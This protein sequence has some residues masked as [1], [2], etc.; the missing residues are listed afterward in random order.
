MRITNIS[1][2][3]GSQVTPI[4]ADMSNEKGPNLVIVD[5]FNRAKTLAED[6]SFFSSKNIYVFSHEDNFIKYVAKSREIMHE[7]I[8]ILKAIRNG[9]DCIVISP[10]LSAMKKVISRKNFDIGQIELKV[11]DRIDIDELKLELIKLGYERCDYVEAKGQFSIRGGI[12]DI[13]TIDSETP[14]RIELFD[15]EIDTIRTFEI[16]TQR[17]ISNISRI[18]VNVSNNF[19]IRDEDF[20]SARESL[21]EEYTFH[22]N[23]LKIKS[24]TDDIIEKL[25]KRRDELCEHLD[26]KTNLEVLD[27]YLHYFPDAS[28]Y[29]WNYIEPGCVFVENPQ[30]V[31]EIVKNEESTSAIDFQALL[32][33]GYVIPADWKMNIDKS[34]LYDIYKYSPLYIITPFQSQL[35]G[36][37][38]YDKSISIVAKDM[39]MFNGSLDLLESELKSYI[40]ENFEINILM[41][42]ADKLTNIRDFIELS[43]DSPK[44]RY[45]IGTL[46]KGFE[47]TEKKICYIC[48]SDISKSFRSNRKKS[49]RK[50]EKKS[51]IQVF[52]DIKIGDYIVHEYH[53]IGRFEA[54]EQQTVEKVT[55]DYLKIKYAGTDCLFV[56]VEK[57]D[58]LQKYIASEGTSPKLSS[59]AGSDWMKKK[60]KAKVAIAEMAGELLELFAKR[61][62]AH[63]YSF[64]ED[65][66]WQKEMEDDFDHAETDDQLRAIE[67][68]KEDM[69]K[70]IAMDRLLCGDV[71]YGKTEV[72]ARA[73]FKC[74]SS[75]KQCAVLVPTTILANQHYHT[76][77]KRFK[78]YPFNVD[79]L[80][81][82]RT[83]KEQAE[84]IKSIDKGSTDL[85]VGTHMLLLN[86]ISFNNL[87]LLVIDEEQRFGVTHKEKIKQLKENVDVLYLS[88]T[89]I[90]RTLDMSLAGIKDISLI[91]EPPHD[92]Y[93]VQTYVVEEDY[94]AIKDIIRRE[95]NR[96]GQVFILHNKIAGI[97]TVADKIKDLVPEANVVVGHGRMNENSLENVMLDFIEGDANVLVCTTII[98][99]GID[100]PNANTII[101]MD[102]DRL[103]LS[104]LYQLRGRVGR[105]N[106]IAY[107]YLMYKKNKVLSEIA[108]KRLMAIK[109]FTELGSGFKVAMRDLEIRGA[110]NL[111]GSE[112]SGHMHNIGYELYWRLIDEEVQ[113]LKGDAPQEVDD[114]KEREVKIA[115]NDESNIPNSY[116]KNENLR[117]DVYKKISRI[118]DSEDLQDL[119]DE[120]I[121]RFGIP[122]I[123]TEK[124]L[125]ISLIRHLCQELNIPMVEESKSSILF[126]FDEVNCLTP[127]AFVY[128]GEEFDGK[129]TFSAGKKPLIELQHDTKNKLSE[130]IKVLSIIKDNRHS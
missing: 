82:F 8:R 29:I 33:D 54:V 22:A 90:P 70:P 75:G 84:I 93:P 28:E 103:G 60:A 15:I 34:K 72:A 48:E 96:D 101:I 65:T 44:I 116:I 3:L 4:I 62:M 104:Q 128:I 59:L 49:N 94:N 74:L 107:A 80:S 6:L 19:I 42:T 121:D 76:L 63:G 51:K 10:I 120:L 112:Q 39:M 127:N 83:K 43:I 47:F 37:A 64:E 56:P 110:G 100:I 115:L 11:T 31:E 58:L 105:S 13:F 50:K 23:E 26:N 91:E 98:E 68:I 71:G 5:S 124:L 77:Y 95:L 85:I 99:A 40:H 130:I 118:R 41:D 45:H 78:K 125:K 86:G 18:V 108:T 7:R 129:T 1:G 126:H 52:T 24:G 92:R 21:T 73:I 97:F 79:M 14:Y 46:S 117:I 27:N 2:I 9:E 109:D 30:V 89:P 25:I 122:P 102:S 119:F 69:Q 114:V 12:I 111:L 106:K 16:D 67:E 87:G 17:S 61:K 36:I 35:E 32:E 88:A 57:M 113:R 55:K 53:G 20:K 66:I 123:Q 81:R 38:T